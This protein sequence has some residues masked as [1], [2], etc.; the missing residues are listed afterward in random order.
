MSWNT[1]RENILPCLG[2]ERY[3]PRSTF[4]IRGTVFFRPLSFHAISDRDSENSIG[5]RFSR[6]YLEIRFM[7]NTYL[8]LLLAVAGQSA[9]VVA[10]AGRIIAPAGGVGQDALE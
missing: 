8:S 2:V 7:S 5:N 4:L 10:G 6:E 3:V 1:R 9:V